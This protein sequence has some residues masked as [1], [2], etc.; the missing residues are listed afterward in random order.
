MKSKQLTPWIPVKPWDIS[1]KHVLVR[2]GHKLEKGVNYFI[3][4]LE[5]LSCP[6]YF[7][8]EGHPDGFYIIFRAPYKLACKINNCGFFNIA[9]SSSMGTGNT[10][11]L[12]NMSIRPDLDKDSKTALLRWASESW[13]K[14]LVKNR[15]KYDFPFLL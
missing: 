8:C 3:E 13:E 12:W 5:Q 11:N 7:S 2:N 10:N 15:R 4:V 1:C 9:I 14:L 6:T